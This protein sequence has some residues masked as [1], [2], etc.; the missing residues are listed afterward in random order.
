MPSNGWTPSRVKG[1]TFCKAGAQHREA[2][3][4]LPFELESHEGGCVGAVE[5]Q[6][7]GVCVCAFLCFVRD[8][9][10]CSLC[11]VFV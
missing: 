6:T 5:E 4:F 10:L 3:G 11:L 1:R 8:V 2:R 9:Q 7:Q